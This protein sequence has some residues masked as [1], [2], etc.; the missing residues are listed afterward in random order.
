MIASRRTRIL[1]LAGPECRRARFLRLAFQI[2]VAAA[3]PPGSVAGSNLE[4]VLAVPGMASSPQWESHPAIDPQTGDFWFVRSDAHFSGW[5]ILRAR[6]VGGRLESPE[7]APLAAPG[8]EADPFFTLDGKS[9]YFVSTRASGSLKSSGLDIW[10]AD[11]G[12]G[13]NWSKPW[14]LAEPVNSAGAEWFPR[15]EA[16]GW[17][18]F[19]SDRQGGRGQTDIW[20]GRQASNGSWRIENAG[21]AINGSGN[22]YEFAVAPNGRRAILASDSGLYLVRRAGKEWLP[23]VRLGPAINANGSEIGPLWAADN[24]GFWFSRDLGGVL[25][26]E[27]LFARIGKRRSHFK[28]SDQCHGIMLGKER[29]S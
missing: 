6:C 9:L 14:R 3:L 25:S 27:I 18:Y 22:D 8:L 12:A 11:R 5:R 21:P 26:G 29:A 20:R 2:L 1:I 10:R 23:R 28:A 19:G 16:D 24:A 13:G 15:P 4:K 17:L 7:P